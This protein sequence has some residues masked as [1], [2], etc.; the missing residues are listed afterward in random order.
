M[1]DLLK[2]SGDI[3][4][5]YREV[6]VPFSYAVLD[7]ERCFFE[8]PQIGDEDFSIAFYLIDRNV[9]DKFQKYFDTTWK[10][11][12]KTSSNELFSSFKNL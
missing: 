6:E 12:D 9:A 10:E 1:L 2:A 4:R 7:G 8:F 11:N 3:N 5:V